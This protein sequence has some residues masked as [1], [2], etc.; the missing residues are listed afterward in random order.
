[1]KITTRAINA[2]K[3]FNGNE[4]VENGT[5]G[6]SRDSFL[7]GGKGKAIKPKWSE[8]EISD[9]DMYTGYS[10]AAIKKRANR[11]SVLGKKFLYTE[12]SVSVMEEA[13]AQNKK[14]IH[15][16]L[17]LIKKSKDFSS[18]KFWHDISTYLDLEGVYYLMAVRAVGQN[19]KGEA[20]VGTA[21]KLVMLNPYNIKRVLKQSDGTL[22]GY[23]ESKAGLYREIPKEMIIEIRLLNPFDNDLPFSM[24]D[25]AKDSQF[26][27]KQAGD[28]T[29]HSIQGNINAPGAI[30]T[31]VIIDD[32]LFDNFVNRIKN[33]E[34]GEPLYGNGAGGIN[35]ESMQI[36]LDKA[37]LDKINEIHRSTLF[38]VSG[39]SKTSMGIEE[40]GTGREVSKTQKDD[41]TENAVMPQIEDIIDA[42]NLDYRR[43][44]PEWDKNEYEIL[45]DNPL[46]S[47]REAELK[48]IEIRERELEVRENLL[49]LGYEYEIAA[50]YAH[51]DISLDELG[52][53]TLEPVITDEEAETI[54]KTELGIDSPPPPTESEEEGEKEIE[55]ASDTKELNKVSLKAL[56]VGNPYRDSKGQFADSPYGPKPEMGK[57]GDNAKKIQEAKDRLEKEASSE[58]PQES[59]A[60]NKLAIET[61]KRMTEINKKL[62]KATTG[63]QVGK[64]VAESRKAAADYLTANGGDIDKFRKVDENW[65]GNDYKQLEG[66]LS[67]NDSLEVNLM[68]D[69][70]QTYFK[71]N[72]IKE[73]T[74]FRGVYN[75]QAKAIKDSIKKDKSINIDSDWASSFTGY[76]AVAQDY[77]D[78]AAFTAPDAISD[79]VVIKQ[80]FNVK[81]V[82]YS[83]Q[84]APFYAGNTNDEFIISTPKGYKVD[85]KNIE[86]VK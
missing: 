69:L 75:K 67:K 72:G 37:S 41:F 45:L 83:T 24:T 35:W 65:V 55:E 9:Q 19:K 31:D 17:D 11:S 28:Y 20:T 47:D 38:A 59:S 57:K 34:K 33:H 5:G 60:E 70:Q 50:K 61:V 63:D 7:L 66:H 58:E 71:Q 30:T 40:S 84:V 82:A 42:L 85:S 32:N 14:L 64:L 53:P 51:G 1:M 12:G 25:A 76:E 26:T 22:G 10:Y 15:P 18:R 43:W 77:A 4:K 80:T 54:A 16:Y 68:K 62:E 29:R 52:E 39:V 56:N 44:Y 49:K 21:Q 78:G 86:V 3:A 73:I 79:S 2:Y 6:L 36:D 8:V 74:V 27:I 46:E 13:K 81:D 48:D 23:V